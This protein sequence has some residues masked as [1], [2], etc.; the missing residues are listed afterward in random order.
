MKD[1]TNSQLIEKAKTYDKIQ[2]EGGEGYNP[3]RSEL[4]RREMKALTARPKTKQDEIDALYKKIEVECGS[5]AREW[6]N[7]EADKKQAEYYSAIRK[8]EAEVKEESDLKF[9]AEWTAETT[10][11]R[12]QE[13]NDFIR[14]LMDS[15]GQISGKDQ[16]K[17]W[18]READQ[19]WVL[20]DL[21]KAIQLNNL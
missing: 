17:I 21:K 18:R 12:R 6:G 8:L 10:T 20:A 3:F 7:E 1:L 13:W 9:A 15:K 4:E 14:S 19:G 11:A 16:P 5:V 2:N